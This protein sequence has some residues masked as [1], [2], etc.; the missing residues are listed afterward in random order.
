MSIMFYTGL[1]CFVQ[2]RY[3]DLTKKTRDEDEDQDQDL[4]T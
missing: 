4:D 2:S 3:H 1:L